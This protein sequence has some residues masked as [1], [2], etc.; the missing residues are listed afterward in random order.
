MNEVFHLNS[1]YPNPF[2]GSFTVPFELMNKGNVTLTLYSIQ[3]KRIQTYSYSD[4]S[5]G[6]HHK[7]INTNMLSSGVYLLD[8]EVENQHHG[9][10]I[11]LLK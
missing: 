2:N 8:L 10:K 4:L 3:G 7:M 9:Q 11:V 5:T 1:V 6:F